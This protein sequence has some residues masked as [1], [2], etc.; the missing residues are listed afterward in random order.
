LIPELKRKGISMS[1]ARLRDPV[2]S[3]LERDGVVDALGRSAFHE[4]LT[5]GV[6]PYFKEST[7]NQVAPPVR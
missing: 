2:M 5:D 7:G 1:F 3:A 6:R 4:R